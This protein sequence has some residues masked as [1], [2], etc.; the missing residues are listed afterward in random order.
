[1][2]YAHHLQFSL[3]LLDMVIEKAEKK[4]EGVLTHLKSLRELYSKHLA[5]EQARLFFGDVLT[6]PRDLTGWEL[7]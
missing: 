7:N 1:M 2:L 3:Q 5:R 6:K 4:E